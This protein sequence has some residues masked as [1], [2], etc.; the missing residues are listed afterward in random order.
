MNDMDKIT[1]TKVK[2]RDRHLFVCKYFMTIVALILI[3]TSWPSLHL[4]I[5]V[6]LFSYI[7]DKF[8]Q[9]F[10]PDLVQSPDKIIDS[11]RRVYVDPTY[12]V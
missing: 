12:A 4:A 11:I 8:R 9:T 5:E 6:V 3:F 1:L 7:L 10:A 2:K